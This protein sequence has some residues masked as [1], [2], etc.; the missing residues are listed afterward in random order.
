M[1]VEGSGKSTVGA[2]LAERLGVRFIEGDDLQPP[3]NVA[4]MAAGHP[5]DDVARAPWLRAVGE[6]LAGDR[7]G[8]VAAC[9]AL[10]RAYRDTLR[11]YVATAYFVQLTGAEALIAERIATRH[12]PY[13]PSSLLASQLATLEP[14][15]PDE[16]GVVVDAALTPEAIVEVVVRSLGP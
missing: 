8:A 3:Q 6:R 14:L 12:H 2:A 11:E 15:E 5:L 1:G 10:K 4:R 7:G 9:S 16:Q 13:M